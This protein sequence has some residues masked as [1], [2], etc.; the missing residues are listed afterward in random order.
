VDWLVKR[1]APLLQCNA[2]GAGAAGGA[3]GSD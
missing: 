1:R 3:A 2:A